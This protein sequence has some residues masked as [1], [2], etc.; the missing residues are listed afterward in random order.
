M[1]SQACL[2]ESGLKLIFHWSAH[3]L[4]ILTSLFISVANLCTSKTTEKSEVLSAH[5]FVHLRIILLVDRLCISEKAQDLRS[6][7]LIL[8]S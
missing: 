5:N 1:T 8:Q 2:D 7:L 3:S 4:I 6:S